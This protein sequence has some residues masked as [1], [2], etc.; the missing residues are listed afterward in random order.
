MS[1]APPISSPK[2]VPVLDGP[3]D[4]VLLQFRRTGVKRV[5]L[6]PGV[7]VWELPNG[8][9]VVWEVAAEWVGEMAYQMVTLPPQK[10]FWKSSFFY[11]VFTAIAATLVAS[12]EI[13]MAQI[14]TLPP[15]WN[16]VA[17]TGMLALGAAMTKWWMDYRKDVDKEHFEERVI[18]QV[19][20]ASTVPDAI[21]VAGRPPEKR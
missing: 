10:P 15:P 1:D 21:P 11:M 6:R 20:A 13:F 12:R 5:E 4:A 14:E 17:A 19:A 3:P 8:K 2:N 7:D 16:Q 9:T 18:R